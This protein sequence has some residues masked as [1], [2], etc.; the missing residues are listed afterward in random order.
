MTAKSKS[1]AECGL[2]C[3]ALRLPKGEIQFGIQFGIICKMIDGRRNNI[4]CNCHYTGNG[5][6]YTGS[7]KQ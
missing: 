1:I 6:N 2:H 3:C 5:F 7:P 4:F